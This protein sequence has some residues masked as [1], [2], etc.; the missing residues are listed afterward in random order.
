LAEKIEQL[1]REKTR[2]GF[3]YKLLKIITVF[4]TGNSENPGAGLRVSGR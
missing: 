2:P 1:V 4:K 3:N